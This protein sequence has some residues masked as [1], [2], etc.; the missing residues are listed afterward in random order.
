[1]DQVGLHDRP[2]VSESAL[3][4]GTPPVWPWRGA[5]EPK[6]VGSRERRAPGLLCRRSVDRSLPFFTCGCWLL[7]LHPHPHTMIPLP[8]REKGIQFPQHKS[9]HNSQAHDD[10]ARGK[11]GTR[12]REKEPTPRVPRE[13]WISA[14]GPSHTPLSGA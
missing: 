14:R 12:G 4:D 8:W 5:C 1:M 9:K 6:S 13:R 11:E 10:E 3:S 2:R 7:V